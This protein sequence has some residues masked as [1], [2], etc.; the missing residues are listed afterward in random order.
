MTT[1]SEPLLE[2]AHLSKYFASK[3]GLFGGNASTVRAVDDVSFTVH[4]GETL[5][6]IGESGCGKSTLARLVVR[7]LE[8]TGGTIHFEGRDI[9]H[10]SKT[11]AQAYH[12][13][14]QMVFQDPYDSLNPRKTARHIVQQP[15][16]IHGIGSKQEI[17]ERVL[18]LFRMVGL[19]PPEEYLDRYPHQFSGGQR[20]RIGIGRALALNP[21]LIVADEPVSALDISVR[22]QVLNVLKELQ[23][24]L[25]LAYLFITHDLGVARSICHRVAV[26][27]LG[28][29]VEE[30]P[31]KLLFDRPLHPYT[32]ALLSATPIANPRLA[33]SRKR[34]LLVGEVPSPAD[35][36]SGCR[37]R[38]RCP[39]AQQRC[40][41]ET[42]PLLEYEGGRRVACH[43]V[44]QVQA[45]LTAPMQVMEPF[46]A[47]GVP[48][49]RSG[50]T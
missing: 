3:T 47:P 19:S 39:F 41:E 35:P 13:D 16:D 34:L 30:A 26:M 5:G 50:S 29:V 14:A 2:V 38:T 10:L 7:L 28:Q 43:F 23:D 31:T 48:Q 18:W 42:P 11:E 20:Q 21:K 22:A 24:Q 9:G 17:R 49:T 12:G 45:Q 25:K 4:R 15:M 40:A 32:I 44:D 8:P 1:R 27:Y 6:L 46:T 33:R 37:F 36:P